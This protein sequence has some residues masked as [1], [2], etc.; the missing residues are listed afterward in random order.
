MAERYFKTSRNSE[1]GL[2]V[3]AVLDRKEE[4][5]ANI[6]LLKEKYGFN[7][8][9]CYDNE[10][11]GISVVSFDSEP[12]VKLWKNQ[13]AIYKGYTPRLSNKQGKAIQSDFRD[14]GV[15]CRHLLDE[16]IGNKSISQCGFNFSIPDI[17]VFIIGENW[18]VE[19]PN[20]CV[21]IS[22]MEYMELQKTEVD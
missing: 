4:I 7:Q 11:I 13:T 5:K 19:I 18:K 21:E 15:V 9:Y 16:I 8:H 6:E 14:A 2:K 3:K 1:T 20:D 12:D 17:Y 22:N 10:L